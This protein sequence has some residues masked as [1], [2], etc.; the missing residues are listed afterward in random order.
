[1]WRQ[2]CHWGGQWDR[3]LLLQDEDNWNDNLHHPC[4]V[5]V[6]V[7]Q[8]CYVVLRQQLASSAP[9]SGPQHALL[10]SSN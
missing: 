10:S 1:M 2:R 3:T 7:E 5:L 4:A 9:T 6:M 8:A